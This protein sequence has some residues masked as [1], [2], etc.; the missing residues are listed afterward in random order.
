MN[1]AGLFNSGLTLSGNNLLTLPGSL[2]MLSWLHSPLL[3]WFLELMGAGVKA[4]AKAC[5]DFSTQR[6]SYK[7][8]LRRETLSGGGFSPLYVPLGAKA[9]LSNHCCF[10]VLPHFFATKP[11]IYSPC[12]NAQGHS[13][14]TKS[15]SF[16][17]WT[18]PW[19]DAKSSRSRRVQVAAQLVATWDS[20]AILI[21]LL[22]QTVLHQMPLGSH[23][24][25]FLA[26][27]PKRHHIHARGL[28]KFATQES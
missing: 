27:L 20:A 6:A 7:P 18:P 22:P 13:I 24:C 11:A 21:C 26:V 28:L 16:R 2:S 8:V 23:K 3:G 10:P 4:G 12:H 17:W 5:L 1:S 19:V 14:Y 9:C 15:R 25:C